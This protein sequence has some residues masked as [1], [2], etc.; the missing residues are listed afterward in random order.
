MKINKILENEIQKVSKDNSVAVLLSGGVDSLSIAFALHNLGKQVNAYSFKLDNCKNYDSDKAEEVCD[1]F[2]WNYKCKIVPTNN[3]HK[4]FFTLAKDFNCKKKTHF[5]CVYPFMYLYPE[6]YEQEVYSGW[7][8]D[9]YY[10]ISKKAIL[11]FKHPKAKFDEFRDNYFLPKNSAGYLWHKKVSDKYNKKF[12]APYLTEA[13]KKFFYDKDWD[14]LNKPFQ[15]HHVVNSYKEFSKFKFKKHLNLQIASGIN[16]LFETLLDNGDINIQ[17]K[18]KS[19][20]GFCQYWGKQ[21]V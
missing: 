9:G 14:E 10:G 6:I 1:I 20:S 18:Y 8:A 3:I 19:V 15:K 16:N 12:Y 21:F 2:N 17:F 11:N 5:T 13:V 4:D 7:G